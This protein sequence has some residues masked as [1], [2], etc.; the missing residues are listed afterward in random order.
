MSAIS[1]EK[2][3]PNDYGI[4]EIGFKDSEDFGRRIVGYNGILIGD[5]VKWKMDNGTYTLVMTS[6]LGHVGLSRTGQLPYTETTYPREI[7]KVQLEEEC[8]FSIKEDF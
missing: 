2:A 1:W 5:K 4:Q 7:Y 6:R 8:F 3:K